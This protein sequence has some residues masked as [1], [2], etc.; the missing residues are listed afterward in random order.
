MKALVVHGSK[1]GGTA[2]LA[3]MVGRAL[4]EQGLDV[5]VRPAAVRTADLG[6]YDAVIVGG[7][8]YAGRWHKDARRFV[9]RNTK[10]LFDT[11]VWLFSSGP[12]GD[13]AARAA[14]TTA[15]VRQVARLIDRVSARGHATFGGRLEPDVTGFPARAMA[16]TMSGD[17]RDEEQVGIWAKEIAADVE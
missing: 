12:L 1:R 16:K 14:G 13:E 8:L 15:P 10:A 9:R 7:A 17:W 3:E 6:E 11:Q 2:G 5:T 4:A